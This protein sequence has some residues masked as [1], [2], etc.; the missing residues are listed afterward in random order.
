MKK[1]HSHTQDNRVL[2]KNKQQ[3]FVSDDDIIVFFC[4]KN[5]P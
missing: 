3:F 5:G 1:T 2:R 4:G